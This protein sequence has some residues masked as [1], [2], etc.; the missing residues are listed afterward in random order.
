[1]DTR[2]TMAAGGRE[3]TGL[4][5]SPDLSGR[6]GGSVPA[7]GECAETHGRWMKTGCGSRFLCLLFIPSK[8]ALTKSKDSWLELVYFVP[9]LSPES[10]VL[11]CLFGYPKVVKTSEC[12]TVRKTGSKSIKFPGSRKPRK[13]AEGAKKARTRHNRCRSIH[14]RTYSLEAPHPLPDS[15]FSSLGGVE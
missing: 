9:S 7:S 8:Q 11:S 6:E 3:A 4:Q 5:P 14:P 2:L 10:A 13:G 12:R 1:M 15:G